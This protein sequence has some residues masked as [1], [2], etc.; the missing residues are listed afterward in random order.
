M[1]LLPTPAVQEERLARRDLPD[2]VG[3]LYR[4]LAREIAEEVA[5]AGRPVV[6]VD[7]RLGVDETVAAVERAFGTALRDVPRATTAAE[8]SALLR[9]ANAAIVAQYRRFAAR[10]WAP[11]DALAAVCAFACECGRTECV[12][13]VDLP[14]G[15]VSG[16][17]LAA[18]H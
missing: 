5:T 8:R 6:V 11:H 14:V 12:A 9:D 10:P 7:G 15:A 4:L 16:P 1:W 17:V 18:G 13:E 3:T 2:G